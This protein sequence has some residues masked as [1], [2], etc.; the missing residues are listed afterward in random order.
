MQNYN[1][2]NTLPGTQ[3][4]EATISLENASPADIPHL[5]QNLMSL[6][7]LTPEKVVQL[8]QNHTF[9]KNIFQHIHCN[10]IE[11]YFTDAMGILHK[12]VIDLNSTFSSVV[13]S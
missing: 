1:T 5:E 8:Q 4:D 13:I 3:A 11:N 9:C 6:I 7:E 2:L 12:N 10:T